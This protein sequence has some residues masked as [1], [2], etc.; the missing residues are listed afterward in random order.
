MSYLK[1]ILHTCYLP[2][3]PYTPASYGLIAI[4]AFF[5]ISFF[6]FGYSGNF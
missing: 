4:C 2:I 3:I 1:L 5:M 6:I